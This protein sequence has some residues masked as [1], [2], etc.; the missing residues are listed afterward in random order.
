MRIGLRAPLSRLGPFVRDMRTAVWQAI[1]DFPEDRCTQWAAAMAYYVLFSIF[2]LLLV[3]VAVASLFVSESTVRQ[4]AIDFITDNVGLT[5]EGREDIDRIL[6]RALDGIG[7][8]GFVG[9]IALV[10]SSSAMMS[11]MRHAVNAAYDVETRRHFV[12]GKALDLL[13]V[14]ALF[15]LFVVSISLTFV[16]RFIDQIRTS[17]ADQGGALDEITGA[18]TNGV[19]RLVPVAISFVSFLLIYRVIPAVKT[20]FRDVWIGALIAS[21][22]FEAAKL[23]LAFYFANFNNY[24]EIYGSLGAV[25]SFLFFVWIAGAILL[26]GAEIAA[27]WPRVRAGTYDAERFPGGDQPLRAS[28]GSFLRKEAKR[29]VAAKPTQMLGTKRHR[30]NRNGDSEGANPKERARAAADEEPPPE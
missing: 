9:L 26:F 17:V 12:R 24:D 10:W 11:A 25:I 18:L 14:F 8:I 28:V 7:A 5:D 27:E 30:R 2:P 15:I 13:L 21:A 22:L 16:L 3:T 4:E 20:R 23:L 1:L 29:A 19:T 6:D